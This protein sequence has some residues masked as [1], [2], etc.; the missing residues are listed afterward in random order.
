MRDKTLP[1]S[2]K[3][4]KKS[5]KFKKKALFIVLAFIGLT[6]YLSSLPHLRVLPVLRE[7]NS[8]LFRVNMSITDLAR[9]IARSLPPQLE[10]VGTVS[11]DF[12]QYARQNPVV[13]EFMLRKSAHV[14]LFF[15][16]TLRLFLSG[17]CFLPLLNISTC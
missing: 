12:Y 1:R 15:L 9:F 6:Y 13:I 17:Q 7:V 16:I 2:K 14:S 10:S 8:F 4:K 3:A 5:F 11:G